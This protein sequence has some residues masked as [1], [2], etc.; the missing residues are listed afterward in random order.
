VWLIAVACAQLQLNLRNAVHHVPEYITTYYQ[1]QAVVGTPDARRDSPTRPCTGVD[2]LIFGHSTTEFEQQ[3]HNS[4][5]KR[6]IEQ[7][8]QRN[9]HAI[10]LITTSVQEKD[11]A[12]S[13]EFTGKQA[14]IPLNDMSGV[15]SSRDL[16][17]QSRADSSRSVFDSYPQVEILVECGHGES[18]ISPMRQSSEDET[19]TQDGGLIETRISAWR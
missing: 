4:L 6:E 7:E 1:R 14:S 16:E 10:Q 9:P 3:Y 5:T 11:T 19:A 15:P 8:K 17:S 2:T 13:A 12:P 18:G